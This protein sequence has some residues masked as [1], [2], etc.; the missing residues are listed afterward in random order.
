MEEG[1]IMQIFNPVTPEKL[2]NNR[3]KPD[4]KS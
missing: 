2:E 1:N 4:G 3:V